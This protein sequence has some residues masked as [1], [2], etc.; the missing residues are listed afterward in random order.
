[1]KKFW[2]L[3]ETGG[4]DMKFTILEYG[5]MDL[6]ENMLVA[7][8]SE[9]KVPIPIWGVLLQTDGHNVI[10]DLGCM[11][12]CMEKHWSESQKI[13]D[14]YRENKKGID[15]LLAEVGLTCE[16]ID[17]IIVSHL[18]SDHFGLITRFP[19]AD[20]Y[21]TEEEW[22]VA[23]KKAFGSSKPRET[24]IGPYYY[25]CMSAPVKEYHF[26]KKGEDFELFPGL[27]IITLPGHVAN[28]LGIKV[29]L[30]SGEKYLFGSD[31]V[32]TPVNIGPPITLPG[33]LSDPETYRASLE[34]VADIKEK[35]NVHVMY[36]HYMPFFDTLKKCPEW[37]E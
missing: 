35:E 2:Q 3:I 29:T 15:G 13:R 17:T 37:Y 11:E 34:K 7:G 30:D 31:A 22:V 19:H 4:L 27:E 23:M 28:L 9:E 14:P 32:Y 8:A 12:E 20:V 6:P 33:V 16:D 10:Y 26:V 5:V 24:P 1:M 25:R 18:H 36:S 21:V